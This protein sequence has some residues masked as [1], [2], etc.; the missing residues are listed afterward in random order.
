MQKKA[1][2]GP[3][4]RGGNSYTVCATSSKNNQYKGASFR[5][6]ADT[7]DWDNSVGTNTPGQ[8]GNPDSKFYKNLFK[9]WASDHYFP[10]YYSK[11][12]IETILDNRLI[13]SPE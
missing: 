6:I 5:I 11:S 12:K 4:P 8:S 13:L 2:M 3:A 9:S 10:L 7:K 1:N